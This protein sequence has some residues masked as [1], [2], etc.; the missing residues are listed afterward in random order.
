MRVIEKTTHT[1]LETGMTE[2]DTSAREK[3]FKT[4]YTMHLYENIH[5]EICK[6]IE[7]YVKDIYENIMFTYSHIYR[8]MHICHRYTSYIIRK[9]N[10]EFVRQ[11][12]MKCCSECTRKI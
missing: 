5:D 9:H 11:Y 12:D 8:Y 7:K 4:L 10:R 1:T 6:K 3:S 2:D